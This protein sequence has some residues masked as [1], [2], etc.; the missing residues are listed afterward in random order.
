MAASQGGV[1]S[2]QGGH[3]KQG[4]TAARR[5]LS[6]VAPMARDDAGRVRL[7]FI[8]LA[9]WIAVI[10]QLFTLLLVHFSIGIELPLLALLP[11]VAL[12]ALINVGLHLAF[13]ATTRLTDQSAALLFGYD[14][15]QLA[16]L[17]ELTG[18]LQNPFAVLMVLPVAIAAS[19]LARCWALAVTGLALACVAFLALYPTGLPW[20]DGGLD[21]PPLYLAAAWTGLS[22]TTVLVATYAWSLAEAARRRATAL[23]AT[24]YALA[25]EQEMSA[26]GGQAA[27]AA[28]LL[29]SPLGTIAVIAKEFVRELPA[30]SGLRPEAEELLAQA[31]RCREILRT[32]GRRPDD[33]GQERFT[34]APLSSLLEALT[35]EFA[36]DGVRC[37]VRVEPL[38][39]MEE[40]VLAPTPELRHSLANLIDNAIRFASNEVTVTLRPSRDGLALLIDDDGPGFSPE[41]LDWLGE[42]YLS[43]QHDEGGLGLG[44]FIAM[45][46]LART[47]AKLHVVNKKRGARVT[48]T[49]PPRAFERVTEEATHERRRP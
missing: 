16:Y 33:P 39:Q 10:G 29:G 22:L 31:R 49:W 8:A 43:T 15:L 23:V 46:L 9:R 48:V 7:H 44:I 47:G 19:T 18:G 38:D 12:S 25:R 28:H 21:L 14:I 42:P 4:L 26:L 3:W 17:L 34:R 30:D 5:G 6:A 35:V 20:R 11:A 36:R 2:L 27:A 13:K 40:P 32:L 41:V 24:Q 1:A 45:T 37:A